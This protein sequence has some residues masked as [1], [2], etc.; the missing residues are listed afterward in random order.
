MRDGVLDMVS[1]AI[2][3]P[4]FTTELSEQLMTEAAS[5]AEEA[6]K[7]VKKDQLLA[8]LDINSD[9]IAS[10]TE[11]I[12]PEDRLVCLLASLFYLE[13]R[14]VKF[15]FD[16]L[17]KLSKAINAGST[18]VP[19][20][21]TSDLG[22]TSLLEPMGEPYKGWFHL[23][24]PTLT[25]CRKVFTKAV[26][27][28]SADLTDH[29]REMGALFNEDQLPV[30]PGARKD[31]FV[32]DTTPVIRK[33]EKE[34]LEAL[35]KN[36][37]IILT[38]QA[39]SGKTT[40]SH[41]F[42]ISLLKKFKFVLPEV[43]LLNA[44]YLQDISLAGGV[45]V[46]D[47]FGSYDSNTQQNLVQILRGTPAVVIMGTDEWEK[48]EG[49]P[50]LLSSVQELVYPLKS[51]SDPNELQFLQKVINML[52]ERY[53]IQ[54]GD[55]DVP[56]S[57]IAK[58]G[59]NLLYI[60]LVV[61]FLSHLNKPNIS[62]EDIED[63]PQGLIPFLAYY[64]NY[65]FLRTDDDYRK[66]T[67]AT[68]V[69]L[70]RADHIKRFSRDL[71]LN[72]QRM[73]EMQL[74]GSSVDKSPLMAVDY[75]T[76]VDESFYTFSST[77]WRKV[78]AQ[79]ELWLVEGNGSDPKAKKHLLK[80][81]IRLLDLNNDLDP[82]EGIIQTLLIRAI[83][84]EEGKHC[85][86]ALGDFARIQPN[87]FIASLAEDGL[88]FQELQKKLVEEV[89]SS[90]IPRN[91]FI[92]THM[93]V[94]EAISDLLSKKRYDDGRKLID[95]LS[96][97]LG[98]DNVRSQSHMARVLLGRSQIGKAVEVVSNLLGLYKIQKNYW[99]VGSTASL[100]GDLFF[101]Q[102][103]TTQGIQL[104]KESVTVYQRL[105]GSQQTR[106]V[107]FNLMRLADRL[108]GLGVFG[109]AFK[110]LLVANG[111]MQANKLY[112]EQLLCLPR[113]GEMAWRSNKT[114]EGLEFFKQAEQLASQ[115][116]A[117]RTFELVKETRELYQDP[118]QK[119]G[120]LSRKNWATVNYL[121]EE[122]LVVLVGNQRSFT[123]ITDQNIQDVIIYVRAGLRLSKLDKVDYGIELIERDLPAI[124][125]LRSL[126]C[127]E[128]GLAQSML[129]N[130]DS[131]NHFFGLLMD[132][133]VETPFDAEITYYA[134]VGIVANL[135]AQQEYDLAELIIED[136]LS[137]PPPA[138]TQ[139]WILILGTYLASVQGNEE[140]AKRL[141][142]EL[143]QVFIQ[144][145]RAEEMP[146]WQLVSKEGPSLMSNLYSTLFPP[147]TSPDKTVV[148]KKQQAIGRLFT[149]TKTSLKEA[150]ELLQDLP[151]A[152]TGVKLCWLR[153]YL[154]MGMNYLRDDRSPQNHKRGIYLLQEGL[155]QLISWQLGPNHF[156]SERLDLLYRIGHYGPP[157]LTTSEANKYLLTGKNFIIK[158]NF[159]HLKQQE[160]RFEA[161]LGENWFLDKD[162]SKAKEY[163][164][165]AL[166][167]TQGFI[168]PVLIPVVRDLAITYHVL[169]LNQELNQ[170]LTSHQ[171]VITDY[172]LKPEL[173]K[174]GV[175][176]G[177]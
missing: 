157:H 51:L 170:L 40:F 134:Q 137:S 115:I 44:Q 98:E 130:F 149:G 113:L 92:E 16:N 95:L 105:L 4:L 54:L 27:S 36:N 53:G 154:R 122:E 96:A 151:L 69:L 78:L 135:L 65:E 6:V 8:Q 168:Y 83:K 66:A 165:K 87:L 117:E 39:G 70:A 26:N 32:K 20:F 73:V 119:V 103:D 99:K 146:S 5:F 25:C 89:K 148:R 143:K 37:F 102:G 116:N 75:L 3:S 24:P 55:V 34:L 12:R 133:L 110:S 156:T 21:L 118:G 107:G 7:S 33:L 85:V 120:L 161:A 67:L 106:A 127:L 41:I 57:I 177:Q 132:I 28:I 160:V 147:L 174:A 48:F 15:T 128:L 18:Y 142:Q 101:V 163:F 139:S 76:R 61:D 153:Y 144:E 169:G 59:G 175:M 123:K 2:T 125:G 86:Q 29:F 172:N 162:F 72:L 140:R 126:A 150:K 112:F 9:H 23:S 14:F 71:V 129:L 82:L 114:E 31:R 1:P 167:K 46:L 171:H 81:Q 145:G 35:K 42:A 74:L 84:E 155:K 111:V 166:A 58:S 19:H 50:E 97:L 47:N 109:E 30:P 45:V 64:I 11:F 121:S 88:G 104:Y 17:E 22:T 93:S 90:D 43:D 60:S 56:S 77:M 173:Q 100:L 49:S 159:E 62:V 152:D 131:A 91:V 94:E 80:T 124:R 138:R 68:L 136:V 52:V 164:E 38:G 13:L 10:L 108:M 176:V 63:L 79:P 141:F 158:H